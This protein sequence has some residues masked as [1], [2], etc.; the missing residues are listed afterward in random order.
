[1]L[2]ALDEELEGEAVAS[3]G[4]PYERVVRISRMGGAGREHVGR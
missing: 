4:A 3:L 1:V 2:V